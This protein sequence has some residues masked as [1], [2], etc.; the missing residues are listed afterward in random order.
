MFA[1][2][3]ERDLRNAAEAAGADPVAFLAAAHVASGG[4]AEATIDGH[5]TA[6]IQYEFHVFHRQLPPALRPRAIGLGLAS[7][8]WG[9]L[10]YP[11][12]QRERHGLLERAKLLDPEAAY[13]ACGWGVGRV[14]GEHAVDL[15]YDSA[16]ALAREAMSGVQ[17]QARVMLRLV[18]D[19]GLLAPLNA[20]DWRRFAVGYCGPSAKRAD[21]AARL[22]AACARYDHPV[23][24]R[25]VGPTTSLAGSEAG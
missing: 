22:A 8:R 24:R 11:R 3:V 18:R 1:F 16:E 2:T 5:V 21:C 4:V 23:G 9:Q 19:R 14:L 10:S 17:G 7:S 25:V 20:R 6:P 13:A 15:G 12:G